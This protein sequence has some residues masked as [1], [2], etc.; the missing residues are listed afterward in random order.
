MYLIKIFSNFCSSEK[1]KMNYEHIY[2]AFSNEKY[3]PNKK[4]Y[5]TTEDDYTHIIIIN[6]A[7]PNIDRN[8][9]PKKNIIGLAFE[10]YELLGLTAPFIEYAQKNIHKYYIGNKNN[11]PA[12]F[13]EGFS[14]MWYDDPLKP[15]PIESK[16]KIMSI[17]VSEKKFAPGHIYRHK[18]VEKIIEKNLPIDIYGRGSL[19]YKKD[20]DNVKGEFISNEPYKEYL[21]S[22]CIE[23]FRNNHYFSEKIMSP[24]MYNCLPI[25]LGCKNIVDYFKKDSLFFLTGDLEK[26]IKN[27]EFILENPDNFYQRTR[28]EDI[29]KKINLIENID[30]LFS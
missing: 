23:N 10:P 29:V 21:F 2:N 11:L 15:I 20:G 14:Y 28:T 4:V 18:L 8:K 19:Y 27:I 26:D 13:V 6:T 24:L 30:N 12:P 25:Y 17:I 9:I 1:C 3:G 5:F 7:M 22:I 16:K